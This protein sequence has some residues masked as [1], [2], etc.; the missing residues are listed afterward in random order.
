MSPLICHIHMKTIFISDFTHI[1]MRIIIWALR[2][3]KT[4]FNCFPKERETKMA[5]TIEALAAAVI[6]LVLLRVMLRL[7]NEPGADHPK[8]RRWMLAA[9]VLLLVGCI[10]EIA[11]RGA[12]I[13]QILLGIGFNLAFV[14]YVYSFRIPEAEA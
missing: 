2:E 5:L 6:D 14:A 11:L 1:C 3:V 4:A 10:A 7:E 8:E 12:H 13:M 9:G